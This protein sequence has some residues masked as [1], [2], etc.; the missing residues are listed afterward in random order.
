MLNSLCLCKGIA[1]GV[2]FSS[3]RMF[4]VSKV[5][6]YSQF[7]SIGY[8]QLYRLF[9]KPVPQTPDYRNL[10]GISEQVSE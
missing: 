10:F 9:S 6:P 8:L 2:G 7:P 4:S 5:C 3:K 1:V